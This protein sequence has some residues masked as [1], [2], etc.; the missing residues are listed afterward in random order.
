LLALESLNLD[1]TIISSESAEGITSKRENLFK[2]RQVLWQVLVIN[3]FFFVI[4]IITGFMAGSMGLVA[5]SLDM[6][7]DSIVY[8]LSLIAVG[9]TISRKRKWPGWLVTFNWR[10]EF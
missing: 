3:F 5:D 4:E 9:G 7:A 6:L 1:T 10:W 2:E 8:G